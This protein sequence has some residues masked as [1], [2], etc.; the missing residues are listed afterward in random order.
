MVLVKQLV[1]DLEKIVKS[2]NLD[3][4]SLDRPVREQ[5]FLQLAQY[6]DSINVMGLTLQVPDIEIK[7][8]DKD[9]KS[10][11]DKRVCLVKKWKQIYAFQATFR[12]F[13]DALL[14]CKRNNSVMEL[15][16]Y[17]LESKENGESSFI[18]LVKN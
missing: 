17:L 5:D 1:M 13:A 10:N 8:I 6:C 12:K 9:C 4:K 3:L 15:C 14:K 11:E 18:L 7:D 16:Q 2:C